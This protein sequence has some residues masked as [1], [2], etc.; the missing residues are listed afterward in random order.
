[1]RVGQKVLYYGQKAL[2]VR[3]YQD[4][5]HICFEAVDKKVI[6]LDVFNSELVEVL[7]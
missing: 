5:S 2:I 4:S 1:M 3:L 7:K 6:Y